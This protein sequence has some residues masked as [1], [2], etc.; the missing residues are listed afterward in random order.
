MKKEIINPED[1]PESPLNISPA[2]K[3]GPWLFPSGQLAT[4]FKNGL[5]PEARVPLGFPTSKSHIRLQTHL[6]FDNSRKIA[7][8][9]NT[10]LNNL[11]RTD[12]FRTEK[13][14]ISGSTNPSIQ[15]Y[16][17]ERNRWLDPPRPAS[18][19]CPIETLP[20]KDC[21]IELDWIGVIPSE[22]V[23][24]EGIT[25]EKIPAP[26]AAFGEAIKAA[27]FVFVAG[28]V[29]ADW[30]SGL[31]PPAVRNPNF[32]YGVDIKNQTRHVLREIGLVLQ[33]AGT[34]LEN[35]VKASVYLTNLDDIY[36]MDE[37]WKEFFPSDPPARSIIPFSIEPG[38]IPGC[39]IEITA[40]AIIPTEKL[41]KTIV[42]SPDIPKPL[43][44]EPHAV[45]AGD[46]LFIS[47]QVAADENGLVT[48]ARIDENF[49]YYGISSKKQMDVILK[50]TSKICEAAGTSIK[51][52]VKQQWF[53]TDL[54]E[55]YSAYESWSNVFTK[56]PPAASIVGV[57]APLVSPACSVL[58]D[59]IAVAER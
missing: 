11:V 3:V 57:K 9:A 48:E 7:R 29:A 37:V 53:H 12:Q 22:G 8:A 36:G 56:E 23:K 54:G 59:T 34:S 41:K 45:K 6:I 21:V 35:V 38:G 18:T 16:L 27:S 40:T 50:N 47:G 39:K 26:T 2:V 42:T 17:D 13:G 51:N 28:M 24:K 32:W 20:V 30:K 58:L 49:P 4:D 46:L 1:L 44:H 10:D 14:R 43:L 5:A 55:F 15:D 25:T 31:A 33:A 19:G 52:V